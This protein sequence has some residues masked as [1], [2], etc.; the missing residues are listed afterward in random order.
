MT[1]PEFQINEEKI[2]SLC[3]SAEKKSE[4]LSVL[5]KI[6]NHAKKI[7]VTA[8]M[9]LSVAGASTA[10]ADRIPAEKSMASLKWDLVGQSDLW[11]YKALPSYNE[12][13]FLSEMVKSGSLPPVKDRLPKEPLVMKTG[14]MID[15]TGEYGGCLLYT[16][17]S[18][19]DA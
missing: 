19:R 7:A 16:S 13:P 14:A 5:N 17:P 10:V 3:E 15:G 12:A 8:A 11:E 2:L 9:G 4:P 18:P 6:G 1:Y